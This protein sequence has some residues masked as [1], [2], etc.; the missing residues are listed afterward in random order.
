MMRLTTQGTS[1]PFVGPTPKGLPPLHTEYSALVGPHL[2]DPKTPETSH[3]CRLEP[4]ITPRTKRANAGPDSKIS[5]QLS[6]LL[7][8]TTKK[9]G[10]HVL[11]KARNCHNILPI[12]HVIINDVVAVPHGSARRPPGGSGCRSR[13]GILILDT[14]S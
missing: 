3:H 9:R 13:V 6:L 8:I 7:D 4:K 2:P 10:Y 14:W 5:S 12:G 11:Y 1:V